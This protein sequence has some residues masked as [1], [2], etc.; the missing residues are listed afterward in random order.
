MLDGELPYALTD[1]IDVGPDGAKAQAFVQ[2]IESEFGRR[3][4]VTGFPPETLGAFLGQTLAELVEITGGEAY[5]LDSAGA[6]VASSDPAVQPGE[7]VPVPDL[8]EAVASGD[9]GSFGADEYFAAA[10][11]ENST[12]RVVS[13]APESDVFAPVDGWN[14]WTPWLIFAAFALAALAAF[15]LLWRVLRGADELA[16]AHDAARCEQPGAAARAEELERSN[17]ELDQFASIA[18]HDLQEPL[19]KVQMF[20][21][22]VIESESAISSP[23]RAATTCA[24]AGRGRPDAALIED[25][26]TFSRVATRTP[27]VRG[28][29]PRRTGARGRLGPRGHDRGGGRLGR[30]RRAADSGR[31]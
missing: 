5:I 22:R 7:P 31:R 26:L 17:A 28:D 25:L 16:E 20:S 14:K 30:D 15:A 11:I 23:R 1:Y 27:A 24:G 10:P 19:R 21:Q 9:A 8:A 12:W 6:V 3:I 2:P 29:R 4:L 18:S 13:I